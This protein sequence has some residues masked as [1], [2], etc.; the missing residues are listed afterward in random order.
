M[1]SYRNRWDK[2]L[3]KYMHNSK[4]GKIH[5]VQT[6]ALTMNRLLHKRLP[7]SLPMNLNKIFFLNKI[8]QLLIW[9]VPIYKRVSW[10]WNSTQFEALEFLPEKETKTPLVIQEEQDS[11]QAI[12]LVL[13]ESKKYHKCVM[14]AFSQK[15]ALKASKQ[16]ITTTWQ[17]QATKHA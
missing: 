15:T 11:T 7:K 14:Y 13:T 1:V 8:L 3:Q 5:E 4:T 2:S 10:N 17:D 6:I 16:Y 9:F 12:Y